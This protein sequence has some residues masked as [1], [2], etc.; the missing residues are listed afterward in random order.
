MTVRR[1]LGIEDDLCQSSWGP[2]C[3]GNHDQSTEERTPRSSLLL[4]TCCFQNTGQT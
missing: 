4:T 2:I 3:M 1:G